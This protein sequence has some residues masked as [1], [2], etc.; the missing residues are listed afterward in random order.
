MRQ[1]ALGLARQ[2][3]H[4][5]RKLPGRERIVRGE[6]AEDEEILHDP[7]QVEV[8]VRARRACC[9]SADAGRSAARSRRPARGTIMPSSACITSDSMPSPRLRGRTVRNPP[10][11]FRY[12]QGRGRRR[13]RPLPASCAAS[14][15]SGW[16]RGEQ[17]DAGETAR[18]RRR[19][20]IAVLPRGGSS[21]CLPAPP[22]APR[23]P[24]LRRRASMTINS[25]PANFACTAKLSRGKDARNAEHMRGASLSRRTTRTARS[26]IARVTT[27]R[28][29]ISQG[30]ARLSTGP[31][32]PCCWPTMGMPVMKEVSMVRARRS[33]GSRSCTFHLPH[34]RATS[35][36]SIVR[37][38]R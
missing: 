14:R 30:Q 1:S 6:A 4:G 15:S 25:S 31:R 16:T 37:A 18:S 26:P 12:A 34:A 19:R 35:C 27:F 28:S 9:P 10:P 2:C 20:G 13:A 5:E 24:A 29:S 23:S 32:V 7:E 8:G 38:F 36:T 21:L 17:A 22:T 33:S 3:G 11:A